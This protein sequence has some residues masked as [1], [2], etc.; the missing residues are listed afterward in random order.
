MK[1]FP[2]NDM[3]TATT[4][5]ELKQAIQQIFSHMKK[6]TSIQDYT[7]QRS[8]Q[9][10]EALSRDLSNQI[11]KIFKGQQIMFIKYTDFRGTMDRT[12]ELF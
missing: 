6:L 12:T 10:V 11:T 2:I 1:E 9:L 7:P 3:L 4:M 5:Q 8:M